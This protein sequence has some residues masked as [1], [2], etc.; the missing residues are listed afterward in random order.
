MCSMEVRQQLRQSLGKTKRQ[1]TML[2]EYNGIEGNQEPCGGIAVRRT[3]ETSPS[4]LLVET[5]QA[6]ELVQT[7]SWPDVVGVGIY[8]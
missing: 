5:Q 4:T 3:D 6:A 2:A 8:S 7:V 1:R